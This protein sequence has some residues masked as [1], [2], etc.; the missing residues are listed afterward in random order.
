MSVSNFALHIARGLFLIG[1]LSVALTSEIEME[2][3]RVSSARNVLS[4]GYY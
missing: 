2:E 3:H 4:N 1:S